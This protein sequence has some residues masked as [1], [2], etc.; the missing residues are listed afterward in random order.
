MMIITRDPEKSETCLKKL[1]RM[2]NVPLKHINKEN[3]ALCKQ[4]LNDFSREIGSVLCGISSNK[5]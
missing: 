3:K 2:K 4:H 5:S 1:H